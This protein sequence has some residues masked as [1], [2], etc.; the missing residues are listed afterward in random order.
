MNG[1]I[2]IFKGLCM[3]KKHGLDVHCSTDILHG[4]DNDNGVELCCF[5]V[6][7]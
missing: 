3:G 4:G 6:D 7:C 2:I 5:C 1:Y